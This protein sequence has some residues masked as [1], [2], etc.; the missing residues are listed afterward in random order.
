MCVSGSTVSEVDFENLTALCWASRQGH[1]AIAE[2][3]LEEE[4]NVNHRDSKGRSPLDFAASFGDESLLQ[5]LLDYKGELDK[6]CDNGLRPLDHAVQAN[7]INCVALLMRKG[8]RIGQASWKAA[9]ANAHIM[10]LF[11]NKLTEDGSIF[12]RVSYIA[13]FNLFPFTSFF[14]AFNSEISN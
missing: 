4:A 9:T 11:L 8:A 13:A 3:L 2:I 14:P 12:Y 7:N 10:L 6:T 5:L 1:V